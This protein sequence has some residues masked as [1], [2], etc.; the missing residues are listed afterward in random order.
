MKYEIWFK[1]YR[2]SGLVGFEVLDNNG[3]GFS[4]EHAEET[5]IVLGDNS[6]VVPGTI[7]II[8]FREPS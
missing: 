5:A 2:E 1:S 4:R 7:E 8:T 6:M 3:K